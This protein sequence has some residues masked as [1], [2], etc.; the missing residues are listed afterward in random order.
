MSNSA[1]SFCSR[2]GIQICL[3]LF[4]VTNA[5][6]YFGAENKL[7]EGISLSPTFWNASDG[8]RYWGVALHVASS[9]EFTV[10]MQDNEPLSRA[11][12]IP[13]L[14][15]SIPIKLFGLDNAALAIILIQCGLLLAMGLM[16]VFLARKLGLSEF[17]SFALVIL[18]P[19]LIGLVHH[20]QSDLLFSF[21]F[22][23]VISISVWTTERF[24]TRV[25]K[26]LALLGLCC[27]ILALTRG[28]G[29]YYAFVL[30]GL[31]LLMLFVS[32][33]EIVRNVGPRSIFIGLVLYSLAF[34]AITT[35]WAIRNHVALND[36]GLTQGEAIM[37][38]DQYRFMIR[39]S[40][41]PN[42][43]D[44]DS[45]NQVALAFLESRHLD[46]SCVNR[47]KDP[48][49]K[50]PLSQAYFNAILDQGILPIVQALTRA[51]ASLFFS[52]SASKIAKY[53]GQDAES[54][55]T[56]A[57]KGSWQLS[58]ICQHLK[59]ALANKPAYGFILAV[60]FLYVFAS[61]FLGIIGFVRLIRDRDCH[62]YLA[63]FLTSG[64]LLVAAYMFVG[65]SRYRA[66]LEP[67]LALLAV[68][69]FRNPPIQAED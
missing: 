50:G 23:L 64:G 42:G 17:W 7:D 39:Q 19:T 16:T 1:T 41:S 13:A 21:L 27:G 35:P 48:K 22:L 55:H 45:A 2:P 24:P 47:F 38:R 63:F 5:A 59:Q 51:W 6:L 54:I 44:V 36:Y 67:L 12:P 56:K 18:N 26:G 66:P 33:R 30:P 57:M 61:R 28:V 60:S 62:G 69:A 46:A 32:D 8:Q 20:A 29:K 25:L 9:G 52:S 14:V 11:G 43:S 3:L 53:I 15:F 49:C 68:A 10:P 4:L 65:V 40:G 34:L 58:D 37:M 31:L